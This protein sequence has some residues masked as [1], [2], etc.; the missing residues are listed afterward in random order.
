MADADRADAGRAAARSNAKGPDPAALPTMGVEEE[1]LLVHPGSRCVEASGSTVVARASSA[2]G[3]L[4]SGEFTEY[5]IEGKTP[6]CSSF[7]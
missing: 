2:M 4:V 1:F 3:D 6:P 7:A 5:Q